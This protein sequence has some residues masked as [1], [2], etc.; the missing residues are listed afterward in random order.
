MPSG[1]SRGCAHTVST[2]GGVTSETTPEARSTFTSCERPWRLRTATAHAPSGDGSASRT[3]ASRVI[4]CT[5]P[6]WISHRNRSGWRKP[7]PS[8][9]K[10]TKRIAF[11]SGRKRGAKGS[12]PFR[13]T[14]SRSGLRARGCARTGAMS[15]GSRLSCRSIRSFHFLS[16]SSSFPVDHTTRR[17][18]LVRPRTTSASFVPSAET[19]GSPVV[20]ESFCHTSPST[21]VGPS[22]R[23][24]STAR[25]VSSAQK[26]SYS[27]AG[28]SPKTPSN[29]VS[30]LRLSFAVS[31]AHRCLRLSG[32]ERSTSHSRYADPARYAIDI[33]SQL[34]ESLAICWYVG[35]LPARARWRRIAARRSPL[36]RPDP[37]SLPS[38]RVA[39]PSWTHRGAFSVIGPTGSNSSASRRAGLRDGRSMCARCVS[40]CS[41]RSS[42]Q[43]E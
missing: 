20:Q 31:R 22:L 39:Y 9:S 13:V 7:S 36:G 5:A 11:A 4:R 2:D 18:G 3:S 26:R 41:V 8:V 38:T 25:H 37:V 35:S 19:A 21:A 17:D 29:A 28:G 27:R 34:C 33:P 32:P 23:S 40:S 30:K 24:A 16:P 14:S 42:I 12:A 43:S 1:L 6:A 10:R 15:S